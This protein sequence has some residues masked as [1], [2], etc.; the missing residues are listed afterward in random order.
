MSEIDRFSRHVSS[1]FITALSHE[2]LFTDFLRPDIESCSWKSRVFPAIRNGRIDFYYSGGKLFSYTRGGGFR[3]NVKY[4]SVLKGIK[5]DYVS[6]EN[7]RKARVISD[8]CDGYKDIKSNCARY[9][10]VEAQGLA[11]VC[12]RSPFTACRKGRARPSVV[13]LDVEVAF[14]RK[15]QTRQDGEPSSRDGTNDKKAS[16]PDLLLYDIDNRRL[17][18]YEGKHYS[19]S[20]LWAP[21]GHKPAVVVQM[22]RYNKLL[23]VA[24][25][26]QQIIDAYTQYV[27]AMNT[28]LGLD[29]PKPE[30]VDSSVVLYIFGYD[31]KQAAKITTLLI[32]DGS[33]KG[34]RL[35]Q[36]GNTTDTGLTAAG[37][38]QKD[39][40]CSAAD[41]S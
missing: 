11:N 38:W 33:L 18:F 2:P 26:Q 7:L 16:R 4:A 23:G 28:L 30:T 22:E 10:G 17:R 36:R 29:L 1:A 41:L 24:Q 8:F 40:L 13:V 9:S 15:D 37:L 32:K 5:G 20:E 6:E 27:R 25:R 35:R 34:L 12:K 14:S 21:E 19:N 39:T 31:S 3:T